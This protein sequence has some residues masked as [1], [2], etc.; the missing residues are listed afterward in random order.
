MISFKN[1]TKKYPNGFKALDGID[2]VIPENEFA[3]LIGPSG[4]GKSTMLRLIF[5]EEQVTSGEII[6]D[7]YILGQ[8][9]E[10]QI[11]Y[12][13]RNIG[14]IFQDYKLLP[15][16]TVYENVAFALHVMHFPP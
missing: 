16:R 12:Y 1:V 10:D 7:K 6:I 4:A 5:M 13:R 3:Y 8:L 14:M 11:P 9:V 2:L 15:R